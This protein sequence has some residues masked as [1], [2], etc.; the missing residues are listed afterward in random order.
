MDDMGLSLFDVGHFRQR[1][2]HFQVEIVTT[3]N[4]SQVVDIVGTVNHLGSHMVYHVR[5]VLAVGL[6]PQHRFALLHSLVVGSTGYLGLVPSQIVGLDEVLVLIS[7]KSF[8]L[9]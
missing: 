7:K 2:V 6:V 5:S 8:G 3:I 1:N 4:S 9:S